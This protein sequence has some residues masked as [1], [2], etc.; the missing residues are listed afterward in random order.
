[1]HFSHIKQISNFTKFEKPSFERSS[2]ERVVTAS[3]ETLVTAGLSMSSEE[4]VVTTGLIMSS[5]ETV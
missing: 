3:E 4:K 5:E 1:M 2:E